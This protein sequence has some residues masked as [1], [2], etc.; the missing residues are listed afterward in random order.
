MS[1]VQL[2]GMF[3]WLLRWSCCLSCA[4]QH[5]TISDFLLLC[6]VGI[7]P[8]GIEVRFKD[9]FIE[10][11]V[12]TNVSRNLPSI[13]NAYRG[14]V[15]VSSSPFL[16]ISCTSWHVITQHLSAVFHELQQAV[17]LYGHTDTHS[18]LQALQCLT[19]P[20]QPAVMPG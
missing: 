9:V 20:G 2:A 1:V 14:V 10:T 12:Y 6:S 18:S 17:P 16:H 19:A 7:K 11:S 3:F 8:P 5:R 4:V 15:E 13:L